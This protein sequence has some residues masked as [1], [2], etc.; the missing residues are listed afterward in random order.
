[1][2]Y[3]QIPE[4]V[5]RYIPVSGKEY[6]DSPHSV[7]E[8]L[9]DMALREHID[10]ALLYNQE[11]EHEYVSVDMNFVWEG[12]YHEK[13]IGVH[14]FI[15]YAYRGHTESPLIITNENANDFAAK[16]DQIVHDASPGE[17]WSNYQVTLAT[18]HGYINSSAG[19]L[20]SAIIKRSET[21]EDNAIEVHDVVARY[22]SSEHRKDLIRTLMLDVSAG[23]GEGMSISLDRGYWL[24]DWMPSRSL[25]VV[26]CFV[27]WQ[28]Y[29]TRRIG[30]LIAPKAFRQI[31]NNTLDKIPR[32]KG[33]VSI[34]KIQAA[35]VH[36]HDVLFDTQQ[37]HRI[38][39][40][41]TMNR[42]LYYYRNGHMYLLAHESY[43]ATI[44]HELRNRASKTHLHKIRPKKPV[45]S[46]TTDVHVMDI[47]SYRRPISDQ[48]KCHEPLIVG[49]LYNDVF[50]SFVGDDCMLKYMDW[51]KQLN[52]D[53]VVWA[54]NG[55][56]YDFHLLFDAARR[57]CDTTRTHPIEIL[58]V[59]GRYIEVVVHFSSGR[60]VVFRD[61]CALIPGA[62]NKIAKDFGLEGKLP[63]ID[64]VNVTRED[65]LTNPLYAKY[66]Q[67]DC[68]VLRNVLQTYQTLSID[69]YQTDP[70]HH[71]S[72]SSFGKRI[73]YSKYYRTAQY[74]LYGLPRDV[75]AY[76]NRSYGGGRCEVFRRGHLHGKFHYYDI[77]SS[78]P[79]AG[80][81]PLPYDKPIRHAR[82][83]RI[84][85]SGIDNFLSLH[86]GFY[87]V[88]VLKNGCGQPLHGVMHEG[89]YIFPHFNAKSS[90]ITCF[91]EE[92]R[93]GLSLGYEYQLIDGYEFKLARWGNAFFSDIYE[94]KL[95]AERDGNGAL[96]YV[97]KITG[98][99]SYGFFG[100]NKYDRNITRVYGRNMLEHVGCLHF[101]G[102]CEYYAYPNEVIVSYEK[103]DV[104]LEDVNVAVASAITS[105][106][107]IHL[108]RLITS[109]ENA[110][111]K[112]L[113]CDTDSLITDL[114]IEDVPSLTH[115]LGDQLGQLKNECNEIITEI[116][117]VSCKLYG[118]RTQSGKT[119]THAKGV[120]NAAFDDLVSM[121]NATQS[122]EVWSMMTGRMKK[123]KGDLHVYDTTLTKKLSGTYTKR[124]VL[125]NGETVTIVY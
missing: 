112:I 19:S 94:R 115:L 3:R 63:D 37:L 83:T 4:H 96:R 101:N 40:E 43:L 33:N 12:G 13:Q 73:F 88:K 118:Y 23:C 28:Y 80:T 57:Y 52:S 104:L 26:N 44:I 121:L 81:F 58:D 77:N 70:L 68:V 11:H 79:Y 48:A 54:H 36:D 6:E 69:M 99:S 35:Y 85:S 8:I 29:S 122:F 110:G 95:Q 65:L 25:C 24:L 67:Q 100:Y 91:S 107:R 39:P 106:G 22:T 56:K 45:L 27:V 90:Y 97:H 78:Y 92:L 66:N 116:V 108:H 64:I 9:Y 113:Y 120:K 98:N 60:K 50:T 55:G 1:M 123:A 61:S 10:K 5:R 89:K 46:H 72:A 15:E 84:N 71:P 125:D 93:Y 32:T 2:E 34:S 20:L 14:P 124:Q 42:C 31:R 86:S 74:P 47:E 51:L 16:I 7:R 109:V 30:D 76:I 59:E 38:T 117:I 102:K 75:H 62:L 18:S 111:G 17:T 105:Y 87:R 82:L 114:C 103:T 41:D 21:Y 119:E 53:I 49:H